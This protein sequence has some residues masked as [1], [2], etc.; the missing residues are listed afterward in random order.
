MDSSTVSYKLMGIE[1]L[2]LQIGVRPVDFNDHEFNFDITAETRV[3]SE[4]K[5][6]FIITTVKVR[7]LNGEKELGE[8]ASALAFEVENF[9]EVITK[10][11]DDHFIVPIPFEI[12]MRT[13]SISTTRGIMFSNFKGTHLHK[14]I[15]PIVP[16]LVT[17]SSDTN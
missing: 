3:N 15:L 5:L 12:L 13:I 14:A 9:E 4:K 8:I 16:Q 17:P 1:I 10:N 11:N 2:N 7:E 6:V